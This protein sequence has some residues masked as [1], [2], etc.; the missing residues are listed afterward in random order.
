[1]QG[2]IASGGTNWKIGKG[3]DDD[4]T[5]T[6]Y[7]A[8]ANKPF[9]RY[10]K[11]TN[12]WLYSNNGVDTTPFG[13][14]AGLTGGDGITIAAG[15]IDIDLTDGVIFKATTAGAGDAGKAVALNAA[16]LV[17]KSIVEIWKD[18][19]S[20]AAELNKLDGASANVTAANLSTLT[21]GTASDANALHTHTKTDLVYLTRDIS[22]ASASVNY[23]H[24]LGIAPKRID[25]VMA[26]SGDVWSDGSWVSGKNYCLSRVGATSSSD[27]TRCIEYT[28]NHTGVISAVDSAKFTIDWTK[29]GAPGS[30]SMLIIAKL[31]A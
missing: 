24:G 6:A 3:A 5:V 27:V 9:W 19:T 15:D 11:G 22:V 18:V 16:G 30:V 1:M 17:N 21:G 2:D 20:D 10:D 23:N 25:F 13:T 31:I 4:I 28:G 12:Q 26:T 7:N 29:V 14:G 8:D